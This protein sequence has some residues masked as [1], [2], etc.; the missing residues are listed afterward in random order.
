VDVVRIGGAARR[1]NSTLS[2]PDTFFGC[3][4]NQEL[5]KMSMP[6]REGCAAE[7]QIVG[8]TDLM[9]MR[10]LIETMMDGVTTIL[11]TETQSI[12]VLSYSFAVP[13]AEDSPPRDLRPPRRPVAAAVLPIR[14]KIVVKPF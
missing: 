6:T 3:V 4:H 8:K 7:P 12:H 2:D 9:T 11:I 13:L 14:R 5:M 10:I 1:K